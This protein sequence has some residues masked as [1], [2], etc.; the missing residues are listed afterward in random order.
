MNSKKGGVIELEGFL[1]EW[2]A[3][4]DAMQCVYQELYNHVGKL[5]GVH[6]N[7]VAR[8][9]VSYSLRPVHLNQKD[10][11]LFAILDVIDDDPEDRWLSICFYSDTITDPKELGEV[12]PEGLAGSDGYCFDMYNADEELVAYLKDRLLEAYESAVKGK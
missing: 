7:F 10:R 5:A 6:C 9:G 8:P 3:T 4:G 12:V 2:Q 11:S 1:S